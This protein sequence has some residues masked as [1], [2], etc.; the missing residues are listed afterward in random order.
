ML[1]LPQAAVSEQGPCHI[2]MVAWTTLIQVDLRELACFSICAQNL[3]DAKS[4]DDIPSTAA[5][6]QVTGQLHL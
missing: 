2:A 3:D 4:C 1:A 5:V 6:N